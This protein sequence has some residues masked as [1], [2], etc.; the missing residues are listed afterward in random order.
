MRLSDEQRKQVGFDEQFEDRWWHWEKRA[1]LL[2][3]VLVILGGIGLL[4]RGPL[5]Q[6]RLQGD[7]VTVEYERV[8]RY[9]APTRIAVTMHGGAQ[10][11][12]RLF[13]NRSLL[14]RIQLQSVM[15]RP[16]AAEPRENGAV[17]V[18]PPSAGNGRVMLVAEPGVIG[19][20]RQEVGLDGRVPVEFAQLVLP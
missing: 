6:Q 14:E 10:Q 17:L 7:G 1:W 20:P 9:Q 11:P 3:I 16:V 18:F 2:M 4:G 5:A 8:T 15:P 13:V 19:V 12:T